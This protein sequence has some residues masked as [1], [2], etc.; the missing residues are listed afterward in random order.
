[1]VPKHKTMNKTNRTK[2]QRKVLTLCEEIE[3]LDTAEEVKVRHL[4]AAITGSMNQ[5][6]VNVSQ[7]SV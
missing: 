1:M 5:L 3:L 2:R 4:W 7:M 6:C